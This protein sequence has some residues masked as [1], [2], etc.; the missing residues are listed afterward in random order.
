MQKDNN[1]LN[2]QQ[3][4]AKARPLWVLDENGVIHLIKE[5]DLDELE[6][7]LMYVKMLTSFSKN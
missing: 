4:T 7:L 6:D 5:A 3:N 1:I 2:T